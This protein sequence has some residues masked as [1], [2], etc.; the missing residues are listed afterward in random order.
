MITKIYPESG[1]LGQQIYV[2]GNK[3]LLDNGLNWTMSDGTI[4]TPI[5]HEI[6]PGSQTAAL[7]V[8]IPETSEIKAP[9]I[10]TLACW[11]NNELMAS[12]PFRLIFI[13]TPPILNR[14][15]CHAKWGYVM[16]DNISRSSQ[17]WLEKPGK[18]P[19]PVTFVVYGPQQI[20]FDSSSIVKGDRV[21]VDSA[22]GKVSIVY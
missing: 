7:S 6:H 3:G 21:H 11:K 20:G 16:G 14:V 13:E 19:T 15:E 1:E 17:L 5:R 10:L 12:I 22:F 2:Y 18:P 9:A 8:V 4:S